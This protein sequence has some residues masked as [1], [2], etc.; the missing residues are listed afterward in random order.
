MRAR[1]HSV[2]AD[3]TIKR[4]FVEFKEHRN[5]KLARLCYCNIS[6][7]YS[8]DGILFIGFFLTVAT[9]AAKYREKSAIVAS[10]SCAFSDC[11]RMMI[12]CRLNEVPSRCSAKRGK[13]RQNRTMRALCEM[14]WKLHEHFVHILTIIQNAYFNCASQV[15]AKYLSNFVFHSSRWSDNEKVRKTFEHQSTIVFILIASF[16]RHSLL[17]QAYCGI[18]FSF[19][20]VVEPS[21]TAMSDANGRVSFLIC[22]L[23]IVIAH[24]V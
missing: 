6:F 4:I 7:V 19:D 9:S 21:A 24:Y 12:I 16:P 1:I 22:V 2:T 18:N 13:R 15:H 8:L 3:N 23:S 17:L 11:L 5:S 14:L 10:R 20:R